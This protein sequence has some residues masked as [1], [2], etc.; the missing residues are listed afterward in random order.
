[1]IN[2]SANGWIDKYF[3][4]QNSLFNSTFMNSLSFYQN[5]RKTGFI[6]GHII[7]ISSEPDLTIM[8][9]NTEEISKVALLTTLFEHCVIFVKYVFNNFVFLI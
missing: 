4:E 1:M 7:T 2:P 3:L 6:Y 8:N 9:W 5:I